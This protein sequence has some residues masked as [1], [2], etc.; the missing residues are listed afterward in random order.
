MVVVVVVVVVVV[1]TGMPTRLLLTKG[2]LRLM[3][4]RAELTAERSGGD[5]FLKG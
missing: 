5:P 2:R 1:L 3:A 4:S